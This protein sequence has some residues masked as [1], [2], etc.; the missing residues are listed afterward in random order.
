MT[1]TEIGYCSGFGQ[2]DLGI[3]KFYICVD[4]RYSVAS[5]ALVIHPRNPNVPTLRADVRVLC[6]RREGTL[7]VQSYSQA[8]RIVICP[9]F[10]FLR[11]HLSLP[12]STQKNH[13][14]LHGSGEVPISLLSYFSRKTAKFGTKPCD[15]AVHRMLFTKNG[16]QIAMN[17]FTCPPGRSIEGSEAC[18]ST[19]SRLFEAF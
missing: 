2:I 17:T 11:G 5:L 16:R 6:A 18:F 8:I 19:L 13:G 1:G 10:L 15:P 3:H 7:R 12:L 4:F 14:R 9:F